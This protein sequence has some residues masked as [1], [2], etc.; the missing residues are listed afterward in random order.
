MQSLIFHHQDIVLMLH[1]SRLVSSSAPSTFSP[2]NYFHFSLL[3]ASGNMDLLII[4][5]ML[6][7][8]IQGE[9]ASE[10]S[11]SGNRRKKTE[12]P[13]SSVLPTKPSMGI[14]LSK[15]KMTVCNA[16]VVSVNLRELKV[17][18]E[19]RTSTPREIAECILTFSA[20]CLLFSVI[21]VNM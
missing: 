12:R 5:T 1:R 19:T 20:S 8:E 17:A 2:V 9:V 7:D 18:L 15:K 11:L 21:V 4:K 10:P 14:L 6:N 3:T 13:T 16:I